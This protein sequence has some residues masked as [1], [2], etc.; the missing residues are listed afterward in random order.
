MY[1]D[2]QLEFPRLTGTLRAFSKISKKYEDTDPAV[3]E[4]IIKKRR[5]SSKNE[6]FSFTWP[7]LLNKLI[8]NPNDSK[9]GK[10]KTFLNKLKLN[11]SKHFLNEDFND[12]SLLNE[13]SLF[14]LETFYD[15]QNRSGF[16]NSNFQN[17]DKISKHLK[18][19]FGQFQRNLFDTCK[20]LMECI[21]NELVFLDRLY[22]LDEIFSNR[23]VEI[24]P[25]QVEN[26][27]FGEDI[28][29]YSFYEHKDELNEDVCMSEEVS[30][31]EEISFK[32]P[33]E[34][35]EE[36]QEDEITKY[37]F[38]TSSMP[39]IANLVFE[40]LSKRSNNEEIQNE[41]F[42][43]L[44]FEKLDLI[45][46][47][48]SNR[49]IV[50]KS[51][52]TYMLE[53]KFVEKLPKSGPAPALSSEIIVHTES[54]KR[55]K[56]QMRKDEKKMSKYRDNESLSEFDP[57][58]LRQIRE[59]QLN[60][61]KLLQVYSQ[62]RLGSLSLSQLSKK[63]AQYPYVFD[64]LLKASQTSAFIAGAKIL[65]PENIQRISSNS[66]EE[67]LIPPSES[68][69]NIKPENFQANEQI[70][71]KPLIKVSDLDELGQIAFK[72]IK[73]LNRIQS[74]VFDSA[75][76]TN[77]NL[78]ICAPTGA[79]KTNI[80]MLTIVNQIKK[81]FNDGVLRKDEFKIVYIAPMKALAAEMTESFSNR[82][83]PL[84]IVVRELT[85]D[86]QLT[87]QEILQTQML[88]V[89]P[90]K[91]DVVTRKSLGDVSLSLLVKLLI[92]DEVHLLHDDRGSVIETIV[93]RTLRQVESSQ[94]MIRIVGLSATLPNYMDVSRF[95]NVDP[96]KGLFFF[97]NRFRPVPL[98][99]TF[100]GV[101]SPNKLMQQQQMDE[102]CYE[103]VLKM[104]K[105]GH[106]VMVFVHARNATLKTALKLRDIAK[107]SGE[108][109][110]FMPEDSKEYGNA[111]K[112]MSKSRNKQLREIFDDGFSVHHAGL[113]R[114]DRNLVEKL[115][116]A[117][118]IKVR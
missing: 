7:S 46:F 49:Q 109:T 14:I 92:I 20:D 26:K 31:D 85:G 101:K 60:E 64:S 113:L 67:V 117:G 79:G 48:L 30:E 40:I 23:K 18:D 10:L 27:L 115:F 118:H 81:H 96:F 69:G 53:P 74:I 84:G 108:I 65:L 16:G 68:I 47:L 98:A 105:Q 114:A 58:R 33:I 39:E 32:F 51:F 75:Y 5:L 17:F 6:D 82:L 100:I 89:T 9:F 88:V 103:K 35:A 99:Q 63:N 3:E 71:L 37:L 76:N 28:C 87:K 19:K 104:V 8:P 66:H 42:E 97:D 36:V 15:F 45:E 90:E 24:N 54:E 21:F 1:L 12:T 50:C 29:F 11:V 52:R 43:L 34:K 94:K 73:N 86:M 95:L 83:A 93:A 59:E 80:A 56:K 44:G 13:T 38:W 61:A 72:N 112:L 77:Q 2:N 111:Q 62:K 102:C 55:I 4:E 22:F 70:C 116:S 107:N 41:L 110:F 106:Q 57:V 91:W 78:L 25:D